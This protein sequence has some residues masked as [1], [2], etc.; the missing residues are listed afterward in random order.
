MVLDGAIHNTTENNPAEY[1]HVARVCTDRCYR[2]P[3]RQDHFSFGR[4]QRSCSGYDRRPY[5]CGLVVHS[6][7]TKKTATPR[8]VTNLTER[9]GWVACTLAATSCTQI[10]AEMRCATR[11]NN[12]KKAPKPPTAAC[13][14]S[15]SFGGAV[16]L[17]TAHA[18][19]NSFFVAL[20]ALGRPDKMT[21]T[22]N[23]IPTSSACWSCA[24]AYS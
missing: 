20:N 3:H 17:M 1:R 6:K 10:V 21:V 13:D 12:A 24:S 9:R 2:Y 11:T 22:A 5:V 14:G 8:S 18:K 16:P 7:K 19:L 15:S 4:Q 23:T